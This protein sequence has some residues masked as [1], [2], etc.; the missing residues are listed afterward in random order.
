MAAKFFTGL[1]LDGPDPECVRGLGET[2]LA[3]LGDTVP[4]KPSLDHSRLTGSR[5]RS[6]EG[7]AGE[8]TAVTVAFTPRRPDRACEENPLANFEPSP[9]SC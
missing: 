7:A 5:D 9:S 2:S 6:A 4:P 1:P 3:Q 8:Q